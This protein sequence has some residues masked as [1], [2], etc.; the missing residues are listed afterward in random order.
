MARRPVRRAAA[1]LALAGALCAGCSPRPDAA[2]RAPAQPVAVPD[3]PVVAPV[4]GSVPAPAPADAASASAASAA[5]PAAAPFAARSIVVPLVDDSRPTVSYGVTIGDVRALTTV[6]WYPGVAGRWPLVVFAHGYEVGPEPYT[7]LL[8]AWADAGYVVAAPMF[9]L[10]DAAVAGDDLDESD[11]WNQPADVDFVFDALTAPTSPVAA[12]IDPT[13]LAVAGHSDGGVTA[14]A[15]AADPPP[16]LRAVLA[17]SAAP[18]GR[19]GENP[20][21]L[22]VH[23]D[24]D[25]IDG[26]ENGEEVY[27]EAA[28]PKFVAWL[29]GGGHLPPFEEGSTW[30]DVVDRVTIDFLNVYVADRPVYRSSILGD[31]EPGLATVDGMP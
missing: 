27:D 31:G 12:M 19:P 6:V 3:A 21:L 10:T 22:V 17:L 20:P 2:V 18:V 7:G 23:G 26:W 1:A 8:R 4:A 9:P 30:E 14:L 16:G 15:V 28:P 25:E 13:R 11:L 24:A 29:L 5:D